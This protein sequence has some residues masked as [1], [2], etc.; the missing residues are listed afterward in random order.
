MDSFNKT[1][2]F[3]TIKTLSYI[4]V[5]GVADKTTRNILVQ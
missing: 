4:I 3:T 2:D 1:L 5:S